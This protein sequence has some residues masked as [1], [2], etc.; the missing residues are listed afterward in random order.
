MYLRQSL[1]IYSED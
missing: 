1:G